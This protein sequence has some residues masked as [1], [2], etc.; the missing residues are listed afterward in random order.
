MDRF[1]EPG[2]Y[3]LFTSSVFTTQP[4]GGAY[5]PTCFTTGPAQ[6]GVPQLGGLCIFEILQLVR[7][8]VQSVLWSRARAIII[9]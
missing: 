5:L 3:I 4:V 6:A 8:F 2:A 1:K 7:H 9:L